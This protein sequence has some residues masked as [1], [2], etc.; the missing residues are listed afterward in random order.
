MHTKRLLHVLVV[1]YLVV[2]VIVEEQRRQ[3]SAYAEFLLRTV[4]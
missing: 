2:V 1:L 4:L 3:E